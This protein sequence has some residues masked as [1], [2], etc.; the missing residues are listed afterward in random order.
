MAQWRDASFRAPVAST[1]LLHL[2]KAF[3]SFFVQDFGLAIIF[4]C[5]WKGLVRSRSK[6]RLE[7]SRLQNFGCIHP[8]AAW[9]PLCKLW[10]EFT[11]S[12]MALHTERPKH[13][14]NSWCRYL[15]CQESG[16]L[17]LCS[18]LASGS[19][20]S[21]S[22]LAF[23]PKS[24]NQHDE[25][26]ESCSLS[27]ATTPLICRFSVRWIKTRCRLLT[28]SRHAACILRFYRMDDQVESELGMGNM[29]ACRIEDLDGVECSSHVF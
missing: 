4:W 29:G 20:C 13:I 23:R 27:I 22:R 18:L 21:F 25:K 3:V 10:F 16:G 17:W 5:V 12:E 11:C 28:Q 2:L 8:A 7:A 26:T 24:H 15:W 1:T 19:C 6:S 14:V 9:E